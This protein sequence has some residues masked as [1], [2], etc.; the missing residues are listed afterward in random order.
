MDG[1]NVA[2][3]L[4]FLSLH[5]FPPVLPSS[6]DY[7]LFMSLLYLFFLS[8]KL[9]VCCMFWSPPPPD[10]YTVCDSLAAKFS[11]I[12]AIYSLVLVAGSVVCGLITVDDP[13]NIKHF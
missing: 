12:F 6:L 3:K 11:I 5:P 2:T 9:C 10:K 4:Y 1:C 7:T 13:F 8:C